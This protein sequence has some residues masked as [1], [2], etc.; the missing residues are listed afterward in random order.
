MLQIKGVGAHQIP[1]TVEHRLE[2]TRRHELFGITI[3]KKRKRKKRLHAIEEKNEPVSFLDRIT[4]LPGM[5]RN[6][7]LGRDM[8]ASTISSV[9]PMMERTLKIVIDNAPLSKIGA[10]M[11]ALAI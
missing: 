5:R 1:G 9:L 2:G 6:V 3:I 11:A 7:R 8:D 4:L 10:E